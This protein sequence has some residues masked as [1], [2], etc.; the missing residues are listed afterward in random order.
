[1]HTEIRWLANDMMA[2]PVQDALN[3]IEKGTPMRVVIGTGICGYVTIL[4][5]G[6]TYLL[7]GLPIKF[8]YGR[9]HCA[10][11]PPDPPFTT[12]D[13]E[14]AISY[15]QTILENIDLDTLPK[16]TPIQPKR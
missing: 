5:T 6:A 8:G 14:Y 10:Q 4:E 15:N 11:F 3:D 2:D 1:M 7:D 16:P 12:N 9:A 13:Y